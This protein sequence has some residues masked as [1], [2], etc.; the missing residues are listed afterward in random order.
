MAAWKYNHHP[1]EGSEEA[2]LL[3]ILKT[4]RDWA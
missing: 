3:A 4:P 1:E 2:R